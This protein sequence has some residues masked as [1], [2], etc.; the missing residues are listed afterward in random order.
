MPFR[1]VET[2]PLTGLFEVWPHRF[3]PSAYTRKTVER[4][5]EGGWLEA[6]CWDGDARAIVYKLLI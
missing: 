3:P 5:V 4:L 2:N 6:V 1:S